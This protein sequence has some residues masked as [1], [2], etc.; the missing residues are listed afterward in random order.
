MD[1]LDE[2]LRALLAR[3]PADRAAYAPWLAGADGRELAAL[4]AAS[5]GPDAVGLGILALAPPSPLTRGALAAERPHAYLRRSIAHAA[6][7]EAAG[8][9][10]PGLPEELPAPEPTR[11][12]LDGRLP[13]AVAATCDALGPRTPV[14]LVPVLESAIEALADRATRGRLSHLHT[15]AARDPALL[16]LG[17]APA[18]LRALANAVLGARPDHS[19]ASLLAGFLVDPAWRPEES[20]PHRAAIAAYQRRMTH[21]E[22]LREAG[23]A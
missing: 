19:R 3:L 12:R 9:S 21:A 18:Q 13:A 7:R 1:E 8:A 23:A 14:R 2:R 20:P 15:E 16:S 11:S 4:L 10:L 17:F 5:V 22:R 6:A